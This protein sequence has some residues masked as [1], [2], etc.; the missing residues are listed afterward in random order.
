MKNQNTK[1]QKLERLLGEAGKGLEALE[2]LYS[3]LMKQHEELEAR[4]ESS[5]KKKSA[6]NTKHLQ[7]SDVNK[8]IE[9]HIQLVLFQTVN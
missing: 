4:L 3:A 6:R 7:S 2:E 8:S 1:I 9:V 5:M